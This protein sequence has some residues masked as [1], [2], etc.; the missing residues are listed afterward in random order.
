MAQTQLAAQMYTVA[1]VLQ[2]AGGPRQ[3]ARQ[4]QE[5]RLRR[6]ADLGRMRDSIFGPAQDAAGQRPRLLR[7]AHSLR[8]DAGQPRPGHPGPLHDRVQVP[9]HRRTAR[10]LSQRRGLSPSSQRKRTRVGKRLAEGGLHFGYHNHSFELEKFGDR[11][12]LAIIYEDSDPKY[13]KAEIDTYWIQHGG[14]DSAA[15]ITRL[16]GRI[17][18][19]HLKDMTVREGKPIMAEVGEGNLNWPAHPRRVQEVRRRVVY[20]RA[21]HLRARPVR[22]PRDLAQELEELGAEVGP[23]CVRPGRSRPGHPSSAPIVKREGAQ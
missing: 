16:A 19:V 3:D 14:G 13:L 21:G 10:R 22:K 5:D 6:R 11:T 2:D 9:R 17:P 20:R 18:L 4:G 15:W 12:G 23:S 7:H 1:R 8:A